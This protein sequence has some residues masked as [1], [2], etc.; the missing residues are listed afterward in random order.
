MKFLLGT[1]ANSDSIDFP[2]SH[3]PTGSRDLR[4]I[5]VVTFIVLLVFDFRNS[6]VKIW[7]QRRYSGAFSF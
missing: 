5:Q 3:S 6:A 4:F 1:C 2:N 7:K